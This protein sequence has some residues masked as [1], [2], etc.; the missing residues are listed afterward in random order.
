[1]RNLLYLFL[2]SSIFLTSCVKDSTSLN[3]ED[4][5]K[6]LESTDLRSENTFDFSFYG[7]SHNAKLDYV[8]T[9][10]NFNSETLE[11]IYT[12]GTGYGDV[13]FNSYTADWDL[14]YSGI[15]LIH[16]LIENPESA[17]DS[18]I[19][20]GI[21]STEEKELADKISFILRDAGNYSNQSNKELSEIIQELTN[22]EDYIRT[23]YNVVYNTNSK[24][25]NIGA[26]YLAACSIAK[27]SF[28]YWFD[29]AENSSHPWSYRFNNL[30]TYNGGEID[31]G[32]IQTRICWKC[33]W[34]AIKV[35]ATDVWGFVAAED[36]GDA[37]KGGYDL[38]C[39]WENAGDKSDSVP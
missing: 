24:I 29:V 35:A 8:A 31:N 21:L 19:S 13:Y 9:M 26:K 18:L 6:K 39:A 10:P 14:N 23:N 11:A 33:I 38:G 5:A 20:L 30:I 25:G 12:F 22:L 16:Y 36:C 17:S 34:R 2:G 27:S 15:P 28:T 7:N 4:S 3:F 1:M 32:Q 37:T